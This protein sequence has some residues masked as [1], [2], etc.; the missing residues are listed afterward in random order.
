MNSV[1]RIAE[2]PDACRRV[3]RRLRDAFRP[4]MVVYQWMRPLSR[5]LSWTMLSTN[6]YSPPGHTISAGVP[7]AM[8][9][10]EAG[11]QQRRQTFD[12]MAVLVH[13]TYKC[14]FFSQN[15]TLTGELA[16]WHLAK[17]QW[18]SCTG[19]WSV[20]DQL[21]QTFITGQRP[22]RA[23]EADQP[24]L[25]NTEM[26][27]SVKGFASS[28]KCSICSGLDN[29]TWRQALLRC[30]LNADS[31][32]TMEYENCTNGPAKHVP[33]YHKTLRRS[34]SIQAHAVDLACNTSLNTE[35]I[36]G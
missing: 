10:G 3:R 13:G 9:S 29:H 18:T 7:A 35:E 34:K 21:F 23:A 4:S 15:S 20:N 27:C 16:N 33:Y 22:V 2:T 12:S 5:R 28:T 11:A 31:R 24:R 17:I 25:K 30:K 36:G 1:V 32:H 26:T 19:C 14:S 6:A 8:L